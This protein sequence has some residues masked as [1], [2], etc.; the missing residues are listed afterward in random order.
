M[1]L[2]LILILPMLTR[3]APADHL[4]EPAPAD[5]LA[6]SVGFSVGSDDAPADDASSADSDPTDADLRLT[7][8]PTLLAFRSD[9]MTPRRTMPLLPIL[10]LPMLTRRAPADHL[11]DPAPADHLADSVGFS[12]GFDDAP[13]DDASSANADPT[14]D[15]VGSDQVHDVDTTEVDRLA[16]EYEDLRRAVATRE[17][18]VAPLWIGFDALARSFAQRGRELDQLKTDRALS[19]QELHR[20][21]SSHAP[22]IEELALL[23]AERDLLT[24]DRQ[25]Q[26]NHLGNFVMGLPPSVGL[27]YD[28]RRREKSAA[29]PVPPPNKRA[30]VTVTSSSASRSP[31][32]VVPPVDYV[33]QQRS[34]SNSLGHPRVAV[35]PDLPASLSSTV[36]GPAGPTTH[37]R[38]AST[39]PKSRQASRLRLDVPKILAR[40]TRKSSK[41]KTVT[42]P[43]SVMTR[44]S[45]TQTRARFPSAYHVQDSDGSVESAEEAMLIALSRSRSSVR[46][47]SSVSATRSANG[48]DDTPIEIDPAIQTPATRPD[49]SRR[50][51]RTSSAVS[52]SPPIAATPPTTEPPRASDESDGSVRVPSYGHAPVN[53]LLSPTAFKA[54]P[55]LSLWSSHRLGL[56]TVGHL[57]L[58]LLFH[59]YS[60]PNHYLFPIPHGSLCP[61]TEAQRSPRLV[62]SAQIAALYS[63]KPWDVLD[64]PNAPVSFRPTGWFQ[65]L[66]IAYREFED[67]HL[68]ALWESTHVLPIIVCPSR[69]KDPGLSV[70]YKERRR[71][72]SRSSPQW[73][74]VLCIV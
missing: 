74:A 13:A 47:R 29:D 16:K 52:R 31:S 11:A 1:P 55:P 17:Q 54:L 18:R 45:Q 63:Q 70:F 73:K 41:P 59:H 46:R 35:G 20:L 26:L 39:H 2:L 57:D 32:D 28:K 65:A 66:M 64:R 68:Q 37:S 27:A 15:D 58:D 19:H 14:D 36:A 44:R 50:D 43:L 30:R 61:P 60:R 56:V 42:T 69:A 12:V 40:T 38:S 51:T 53:K 9:L 6:D 4:A 72:R 3:R 23:R 34:A 5:H 71:R 21:R 62:T 22:F 48:M 33:T 7:T 8:L 25:A 10:I 67:H 24:R 49:P